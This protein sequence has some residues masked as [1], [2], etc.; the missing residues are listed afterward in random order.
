V[1][2]VYDHGVYLPEI[3][4]WLDPHHA[5]PKHTGFVSHAHSDHARWHGR[6]LGTRATL[7]FMRQRQPRRESVNAWTP[8]FGQPVEQGGARLTLVPAGHMAGSA[9]LLVERAGERLLYSGDFKLRPDASCEAIEVPEADVLI[10]ETTFGL[11]RYVFPKHESIVESLVKFCRNALAAGET[12][13]LLTYAFGKAQDALKCL[14]PFGFEFLLHPA[15]ATATDAYRNLGYTFPPYQVQGFQS[16]R[17]RVL[18]STPGA[19]LPSR[20]RSVFLSGW[21]MDSGA[22]WRLGADASLPLSD[23][24]DFPGLLEYVRRVRPKKIYTHHGFGVEFAA[25]LRRLGY[26]ASALGKEEQ[27]ELI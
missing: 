25:H 7:R 26:D 27:L 23:H 19:N 9:Q 17:G 24:A 18:V 6:T 14:E 3:D 21:A 10:M 15:V 22:R 8:E 16:P 13:A 5:K 2:V 20:C 1:Q 4:L 11:P 12:P